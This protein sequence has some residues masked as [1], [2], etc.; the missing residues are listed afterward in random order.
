MRYVA[1]LRGIGPT[2]PNMKGERLKSVFEAIGFTNVHP[3]IASGN[4]L[5]DSPSKNPKALEA[6]IESALPERLGFNST[7]IVRTKQDLAALVKKNPFAGV[8]DEK[9]NYLLVTFFKN[10]SPELCTV[11]KLAEEK[12]PDFMRKVERQHGKAIT[13][14][15]WKTVARILKKM[16]ETER[17]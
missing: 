4:V 10:S 14:R 17:P 3:V 11:I 8:R 15:T 9:P 12:T 5:F 6:L 2:N 13:S 16:E 7:T 1:L